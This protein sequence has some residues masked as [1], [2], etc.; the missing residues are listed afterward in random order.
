MRAGTQLLPLA[1]A[2]KRGFSF[3]YRETAGARNNNNNEKINSKSRKD[4]T[5]GIFRKLASDAEGTCSRRERHPSMW[6]TTDRPASWLAGRQT[7]QEKQENNTPRRRTK[8]EKD[9]GKREEKKRRVAAKEQDK[10]HARWTS[11]KQDAHL[12]SYRHLPP[13]FLLTSGAHH[14]SSLSRTCQPTMNQKRKKKRKKEISTKKVFMRCANYLTG[15]HKL[16]GT[17][18]LSAR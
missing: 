1:D 11:A 13:R 17:S 4:T 9:G 6:G 8:R 5:S 16:S 2:Q 10:L 12:H 3:S 14:F 18:R 7:R 15:G